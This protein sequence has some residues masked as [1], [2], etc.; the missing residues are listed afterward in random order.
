[1]SNSQV[2]TAALRS[3]GSGSFTLV[4]GHTADTSGAPCEAG[5]RLDRANVVPLLAKLF[6]MAAKSS[7]LLRSQTST[8]TRMTLSP[9]R[10]FRMPDKTTG[11]ATIGFHVFYKLMTYI[12]GTNH[13]FMA[14]HQFD[15]TEPG[16]YVRTMGVAVD[17]FN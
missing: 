5:V 7:I 11:P 15:D 10:H 12:L 1:M 8:T 3:Q 16:S 17:E 2:L 13:R 6:E 14:I 4:S 9:L